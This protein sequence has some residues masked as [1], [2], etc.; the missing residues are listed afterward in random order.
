MKAVRLHETAGPA[1]L[2]IETIADPVPGPQQILVKVERAALNRRDLYI[3]QGRYAGIRLPCTL[4]ADGA[5]TVAQLGA[6]VTGPAVGTPVVINPALHWSD[7][8]HELHAFGGGEILGMPSDG[9]FAEF[10]A[11]PAQ[12]VYRRP[13][14]LT[15]DEAAAIPLAGLTAYRAVFTRGRVSTDDTV[16][17]TGIGGGVQT[18]ALLFVKHAGAR[19]IVTSG[20]DEKL[21]RARILG[22]DATVN[23][24]RTPDWHK[25]VR[26]ACEGPGPTLVIDSSGGDTLAK[27]IDI[28]APS[29][30]IVLYGGTTG[31]A[32]IRPYAIFWKHLTVMGTSMGSPADFQAMLA[33]FE[34]GLHPVIDRISPMEEAAPAVQR[35]AESAQFGKILLAIA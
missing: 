35:L 11:V 13:S 8:P 31:D 6:E 29:A 2:R 23:Y 12:N 26:A 4:G 20:S 3:T 21:E 7:D 32:T 16:L 1:S 10:V 30:R 18:L 24:K 14:T 34:S 27:A 33:L 9:T 25:E 17:I 19:A 5:G 28:A 15:S 22:A